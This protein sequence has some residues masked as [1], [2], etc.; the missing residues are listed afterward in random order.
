MIPAKVLHYRD[1]AAVFL[2]LDELRKRGLT[3]RGILFIALD[4]RGETHI[5]IPD[6]LDAVTKVR[7][8][9]KLTIKPPWEGRYFHFDSIHRL[10]GDTVLWNGDRRLGDTGGAADVAQAIC[11]WM[12]AWSAKELF[13]GCTSHQPASWWMRSTS[14]P[15]TALHARG[16]VDAVVSTMGLLARRIG[17]PNL[18]HLDWRTLAQDGA[19]RGWEPVY[20]SPL[21]VV[22]MLERRVK[23][24]RLAMSCERGIVEVD[25]SG[26][27]DVREAARLE[28]EGGVGIVGR[29]DDGAFAVTR[30]RVEPWGLAD[31]QPA[32]L[33]GS[34]NQS[35]ADL[36]VADLEATTAE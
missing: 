15:L 9:D 24:Y 30:G 26:L 19:L 12:R 36:A 8:G 10:P 23:Q 33:V 6:D 3:P 25:V 27:P 11:E 31:V 34:V 22:L 14:E 2:G 20:E 32:T 4:P 7:V 13:L 5:A 28:R 35:I 18:Y 1:P 16:F 21:G 17:E 29:V